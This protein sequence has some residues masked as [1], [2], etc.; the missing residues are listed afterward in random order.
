M[1]CN[2]DGRFDRMAVI[3]FNQ[4]TPCDPEVEELLR[5]Y[6]TTKSAHPKHATAKTV[7]DYPHPGTMCPSEDRMGSETAIEIILRY[8]YTSAPEPL[9]PPAITK[10]RAIHPV[11]R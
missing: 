9:K 5:Q 10:T 1:I 6:V 8:L 7:L 4:G 3:A 2:I 11:Y